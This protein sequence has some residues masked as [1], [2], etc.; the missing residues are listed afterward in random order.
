MIFGY[1]ANGDDMGLEI[2]G[3]N[4][5]HGRRCQFVLRLPKQSSI[6]N[7]DEMEWNSH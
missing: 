2:G 5:L 1:L 6:P 3:W 4:C 7:G